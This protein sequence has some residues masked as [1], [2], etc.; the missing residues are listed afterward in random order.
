MKLATTMM[1]RPRH[2]LHGENTSCPALNSELMMNRVILGD[3]DHEPELV[4]TGVHEHFQPL[5]EEIK[6]STQCV[7]H[8]CKRSALSHR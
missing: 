3:Y 4:V 2:A 8:M 1:P 7:L 5:H 6:M